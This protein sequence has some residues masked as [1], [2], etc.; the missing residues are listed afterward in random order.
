M[1]MNSINF[2]FGSSL[3]TIVY[4]ARVFGYVTLNILLITSEGMF[5]SGRESVT[6]N[7]KG[8]IRNT[9]FANL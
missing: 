1:S 3:E 8:L 9:K 6:G 5:N 2:V 7:T 4:G